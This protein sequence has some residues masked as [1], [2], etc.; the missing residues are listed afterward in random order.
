MSKLKRQKAL[1]LIPKYE[2]LKMEKDE[3]VEEML[4]KFQTLV[5]GLKVLNKCYTTTDHV[6]KIIRSLPKKWRPMMTAIKVSKDLNKTTLE[7][8]ISSMR[9]L[10]VKLMEDKP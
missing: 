9:S 4:S 3:M 8:L 10:E 2:S 1:A 7:E 6:K 5:A